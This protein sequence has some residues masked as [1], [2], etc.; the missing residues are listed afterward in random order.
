MT[1]LKAPKLDIEKYYFVL[2]M[3]CRNLIINQKI[4]QVITAQNIATLDKEAGLTTSEVD[5]AAGHLERDS[6]QNNFEEDRG[7]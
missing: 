3:H 6:I 7:R 1:E 2:S 5:F 4:Q